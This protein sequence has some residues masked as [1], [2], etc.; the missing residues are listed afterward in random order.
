MFKTA[1]HY[2][3]KGTRAYTLTPATLTLSLACTSAPAWRR[4]PATSQ[5]PQAAATC[6]GLSLYYREHHS[7]GGDGLLIHTGE[8]KPL[9][10]DNT[11]R[12]RISTTQ[13]SKAPSQLT[14]IALQ[15]IG[16]TRHIH[17]VLG[18]HVSASLD[19]GA[20]HLRIAMFGSNVQ[21]RFL[22]LHDNRGSREARRRQACVGVRVPK[23]QT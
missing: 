15:H 4:T 10:P 18:V 20:G 7:K 3:Q 23:R 17:L 21:G 9:G 11:K 14:T 5:L 2:T 8:G 16:P 1:H 22:G 19:E 13:P 6:R 12:Q